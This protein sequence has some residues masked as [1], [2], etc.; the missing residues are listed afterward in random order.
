MPLRL[1]LILAFALAPSLHAQGFGQG[2]L[3]SKR[4]V[5]LHRKLPATVNLKGGTIEIKASATDKQN[6]FAIQKLQETL[7]AELLK[8]NNQFKVDNSN[9]ETIVLCKITDLLI[10]P[11]K[12]VTRTVSI[13]VKNG[14]P[15]QTQS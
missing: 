14:K 2:L 1:V 7:E 15:F 6:T 5:T 8:Y 3:K 9:P 4:T 13:P 12:I 10:P 11:T